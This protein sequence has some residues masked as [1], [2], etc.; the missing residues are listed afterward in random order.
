M[1]EGASSMTIAMR[2][3]MIGMCAKPLARSWWAGRQAG[4]STVHGRPTSAIGARALAASSSAFGR[5]CLSCLGCLS[6]YLAGRPAGPSRSVLV[7]CLLPPRVVA[8]HALQA[9]LQLLR[10][11]H[12][13]QRQ[14]HPMG[15]YAAHPT[16][17]HECKRRQPC[18]GNAHAAAAIRPRLASHCWFAE[19]DPPA[20]AWRNG[21]G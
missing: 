1:T 6:S 8:Q 9:L 10:Q 3:H 7:H 15:R 21:C 2:A 19:H 17:Q 20:Q 18:T 13:S 14:L 4:C 12:A 16:H 5:R 11:H